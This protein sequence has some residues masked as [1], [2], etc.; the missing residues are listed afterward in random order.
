MP[1][2]KCNGMSQQ[3][4]AKYTAYN[5]Q[6]KPC[7][8]TTTTN[9]NK[10]C[11]YLDA[12]HIISLLGP[13]IKAQ[14]SNLDN[15]PATSDQHDGAWRLFGPRC[16]CC[17]AATAGGGVADDGQSLVVVPYKESLL[18]CHCI[19]TKEP[20]DPH[21]TYR[22]SLLTRLLE[23]EKE[24]HEKQQQQR[25]KEPF[26]FLYTTVV[27][28]PFLQEQS[29]RCCRAAAATAQ[30]NN[31]YQYQRCTLPN[32]ICLGSKYLSSV[33]R[34]SDLYLLDAESDTYLLLSRERAIESYLL[35]QSMMMAEQ[36][37][38]QQQNNDDI[39]S[40]SISSKDNKSSMAM[41]VRQEKRKRQKPPIYW[42]V[43]HFQSTHS[44]LQTT[45]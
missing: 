11:Q 42:L 36:Q 4:A 19:A 8:T 37:Q 6:L 28:D 30:K 43:P 7:N 18:Y 1:L 9:N 27:Q 35:L 38:K 3:F 40:M 25:I 24:D 26:R 39:V 12:S 2:A 5:E 13:R 29:R 16:Q 45:T 14:I 23:M 22:D 10:S 21:F 31:K 33:A 20:L 41:L 15:L 32:W 44:I 17:C 34:G